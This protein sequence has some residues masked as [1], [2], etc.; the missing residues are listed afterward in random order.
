MHANDLNRI[1]SVPLSDCERHI[2]FRHT[3]RQIDGSKAMQ[4]ASQH[5]HTHRKEKKACNKRAKNPTE[6]FSQFSFALSLSN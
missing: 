1:V 4:T 2:M 3:I 5:T 6:P